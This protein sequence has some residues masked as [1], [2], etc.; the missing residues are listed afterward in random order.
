M[1]ST[2]VVAGNFVHRQRDAVERIRAFQDP[3]EVPCAEDESK[4]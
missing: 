2:E 4:L 3:L 1:I